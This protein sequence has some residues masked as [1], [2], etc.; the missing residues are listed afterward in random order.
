M[1]NGRKE[2]RRGGHIRK[3]SD[4]RWKGRY[5]QAAARARAEKRLAAPPKKISFNRKQFVSY[6]EGHSDGE[7]EALFLESLRERVG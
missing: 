1:S 6:L 3:R 4:G 5:T 7:I 2:I